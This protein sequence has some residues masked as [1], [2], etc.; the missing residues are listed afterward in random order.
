MKLNYF[1]GSRADQYTMIRIPKL[2]IT[3]NEFASL[4]IQ[5][6]VLYGLL[7]DRMGMAVK[8][9]WLDQKKRVYVIYPISDIQNDMNIT[10]RKAMDYLSELEEAGLLEKQS[11]GLGMPN[12]LYLKNFTEREIQKC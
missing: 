7:L 12:M 2:L 8:N 6:K 10:K 9:K 3:D 4:T 11:R 1:F 5:A